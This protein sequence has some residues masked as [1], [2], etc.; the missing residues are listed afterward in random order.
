MVPEEGSSGQEGLCAPGCGASLRGWSV[1][2]K[3][4]LLQ[5]AVVGVPWDRKPLSP[6]PP[7]Q[8]LSQ[9]GWGRRSFQACSL[10]NVPVFKL[11]HFLIAGMSCLEKHLE[12][13]MFSYRIKCFICCCRIPALLQKGCFVKIQPQNIFF[14]CSCQ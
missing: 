14:L 3:P 1:L 8:E 13:L 10:L 4:A 2:A 7:G 5:T 12:L 6:F 11:S 9:H